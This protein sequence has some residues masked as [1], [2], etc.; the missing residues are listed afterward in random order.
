MSI[1]TKL[2]RHQNCN[3]KLK[4]IYNNAEDLFLSKLKKFKK[5][6]FFV[7]SRRKKNFYI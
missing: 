6:K 7:L 3:K 1:L 4:I 5:K 2:P